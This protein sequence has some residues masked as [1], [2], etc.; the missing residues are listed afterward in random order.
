MEFFKFTN[1]SIVHPGAHEKQW[2]D[3]RT[4][5]YARLEEDEKVGSNK[6]QLNWSSGIRSIFVA[7]FIIIIIIK[8]IQY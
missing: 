7:H 4:Y 1:F 5:N 8:C 2:E 3:C 6:C